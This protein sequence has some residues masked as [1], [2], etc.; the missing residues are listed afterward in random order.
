MLGVIH[1]KAFKPHHLCGAE[2]C[3]RDRQLRRRRFFTKVTRAF[4]P[5]PILS[6][7]DSSEY[8]PTTR[9]LVFLVVSFFH[10]LPLIKYVFN[11]NQLIRDLF[12]QP[13]IGRRLN[14][15]WPE[16]LIR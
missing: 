6:L 11:D 15:M 7:Q 5:T 16:D 14:R 3:S 12:T 1:L 10:A 8:Y 9:V 4:H 13:E 2:H